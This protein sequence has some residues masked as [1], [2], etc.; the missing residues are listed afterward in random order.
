MSPQ[1]FRVRRF[2]ASDEDA[3]AALMKRVISP[4]SSHRHDTS[5]LLLKGSLNDGLLFTATINDVP[6]GFIAAGHDGVRGRLHSLAVAPEHR[7]R[8]IGT[9]LVRHA[10]K[11]LTHRG[12]V[13]ISLEVSAVDS[14]A[15]SF[16]R[17]LGYSTE[18]SH[19]FIKDAQVPEP[20]PVLIRIDQDIT[21]TQFRK[22]DRNTLSELLSQSPIFARNIP[23]MP[24][25][26]TRSDADLWLHRVILSEH[27]SSSDRH[28]AVRYTTGD[29]IGSIGFT[30]IIPGQQAEVGFWL[31]VN[32]HGRGIMT[33]VVRTMIPHL[34][35]QESLQRLQAR[36]LK[37]NRASAAVLRKAGFRSEGTLRNAAFCDGNPEDMQMFSC[38]P[39][40]LSVRP[41][42]TLIE[43]STDD[44]EFISDQLEKFNQAATGL[45]AMSPVRLVI[46][47]ASGEIIAGVCGVQCWSRLYISSLW[48]REDFRGTGLGSRLLREAETRARQAGCTGACLTSFSFQAP[49]FYRRHGYQLFG[50]MNDYPPGEQLCFMEKKW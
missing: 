46:C 19:L 5:E 27:H 50:K 33:R 17:A 1:N 8:G 25:P 3:V 4:T 18:Q 14:G 23:G 24:F 26:Y 32:L 42:M 41:S 21:V 39:E 22:D 43:G 28:F 36:I 30:G 13:Q 16:R 37:T 47:N 11:K 40:D 6:V 29:L 49:E 9:A 45:D 20:S 48:V 2:A 38:T 10:E 7:R 44:S 35:R 15:D 34:F 12:C 31:A